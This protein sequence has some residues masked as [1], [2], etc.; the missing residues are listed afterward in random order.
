MV[1]GVA[2]LFLQLTA[3][4]AFHQQRSPVTLLDVPSRGRG[5]ESSKPPH[6]VPAWPGICNNNN[7][8]GRRSLSCS[9]AKSPL[10]VRPPFENMDNDENASAVPASPEKEWPVVSGKKTME[11]G[12]SKVTVLSG[13]DKT[14]S[15]DEIVS[16]IEEQEEE[17]VQD[18][19]EVA[20]MLTSEPPLNDGELAEPVQDMD[21]V[22]LMLTSEPPL[23]D[24]ELAENS[25]SSLIPHPPLTPPTFESIASNDDG[26]L[27]SEPTED[28]VE[29]AR[30]EKI[31]SLEQQG[32]EAT[33]ALEEERL[34]L[35]RALEDKERVA[36]EYSYLVQS[37]KQL[38]ADLASKSNDWVAKISV[39]DDKIKALESRLEDKAEDVQNTRDKSDKLQ[40]R[41]GGTDHAP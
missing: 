30:E 29:Q 33:Q 3:I 23:N 31:R 10:P 37:Y 15:D 5:V 26:L 24:G 34:K 9:L 11:L 28:D 22:A 14:I 1:V 13:G 40:R 19:D 2:L 36:A 41:V 17:F 39:S 16:M 38:K 7:S 25:D 6:T 21:E 35:S 12:D 27:S 4:E 32:R 20:L 18:M 8:H